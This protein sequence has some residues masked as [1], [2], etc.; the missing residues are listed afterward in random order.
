MNEDNTHSHF[1]EMYADQTGFIIEDDPSGPKTLVSLSSVTQEDL[2]TPNNDLTSSQKSI[3]KISSTSSGNYILC[4]IS[5]CSLGMSRTLRLVRISGQ[6]VPS[7]IFFTVFFVL[8]M[9]ANMC[10]ETSLVLY[11]ISQ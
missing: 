10:I 1:N 4:D 5:G 11:N 8:Q 3:S 7:L 6:K 9:C 2:Q